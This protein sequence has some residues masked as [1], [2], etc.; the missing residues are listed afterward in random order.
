MDVSIILY[1]IWLATFIIA[2]IFA[3]YSWI[4]TE[5]PDSDSL[6]GVVLAAGVMPITLFFVTFILLIALPTLSLIKIREVVQAWKK[7]SVKV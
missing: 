7:K 2:V 4:W 3:L 6:L 5:F 1:G